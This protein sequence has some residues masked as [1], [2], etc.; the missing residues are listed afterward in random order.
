M[1]PTI[2]ELT[3]E[4]KK[5]VHKQGLKLF[6]AFNETY[7]EMDKCLLS[8][9]KSVFWLGM[10]SVGEGVQEKWINALNPNEEF[11]KYKYKRQSSDQRCV[12]TLDGGIGHTRCTNGFPCGI[13]TI[14]K[15]KILYM[16]GLC[17]DDISSNYDVT[18]YLDGLVNNRPHF[19]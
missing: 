12:Y 10:K 16:K 4:N 6:K 1:V 14:P 19:K 13:C 2:P 5:N 18:Y 9:T 15:G 7:G 17:K 11:P 8:E 3:K